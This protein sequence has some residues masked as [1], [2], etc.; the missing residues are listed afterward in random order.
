MIERLFQRLF[1][2]PFTRQGRKAARRYARRGRLR[3]LLRFG[4]E[5]HAWREG[6]D[7]RT[8]YRLWPLLD[9]RTAV[10]P[11]DPYYFHQD[12]W[13]L[14]KVHELAP[15]RIVD[16]GS[17]ALLVGAYAQIAP[18]TS[19]DIRPLPV[20]VPGLTCQTG[21]M[22]DLPFEDASVELLSSLCVMEHVGLGRYGDPLDPR[23]TDAAAR[24]LAR[25][26]R[27]GGHLL[28]SVPLGPSCVVFN[29]HRVY[30]RAELLACF[31]DFQPVDETFCVPGYSHE[32]PTPTLE[33]G[34]SHVYCVLLRKRDAVSA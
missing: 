2:R 32:D 26:I 19:I 22:L 13:G 17:T 5:F 18:T 1:R 27:P 3:D 21:S 29:A 10:T 12:V 33:P 8:V 28:I 30:E 23:G 14:R 11:L 31:P 9:E 6:R 20:Q 25:V 15:T 34:E 16:V 7:P 24:E 4:S